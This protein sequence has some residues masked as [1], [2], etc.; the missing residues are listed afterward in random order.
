MKLVP[1]LLAFIILLPALSYAVTNT[2]GP[3]TITGP[4]K[5]AIGQT[6]NYTVN[7]E[8]I[9]NHYKI[10]FLLSGYNL[11]GASP[12]SPQYLNGTFTPQN[13]TITAPSVQTTLFLFFQIIAYLNG[14]VFYYNITQTVQV[15]NYTVLKVKVYNPTKFIFKD[16]NVSFYVNG[17][18]VGSSQ[19]NIS[20]NTT[21]NVTYQWLSGTL[22]P[23]IYNI[24]AKINS[25]VVKLIGGKYS[26]DIQVGNP[27]LE[28]V[29]IIIAIVLAMVVVIVLITAIY[30]RRNKP[31]WKK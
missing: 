9:F 27:Y 21:E 10:V 25:S 17:E 8:Q 3:V 20:G 19:L 4:E 28:Y 12:I 29:Y 31:K 6:F 22:S 11:T 13:F 18:Y 5:V 2:Y 14:Q 1:F 30:N 24:Q 23:G 15:L 26:I 16:L 7:V